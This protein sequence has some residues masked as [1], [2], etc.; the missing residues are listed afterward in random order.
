MNL[1]SFHAKC[2]DTSRTGSKNAIHESW[3]KCT[4]PIIVIGFWQTHTQHRSVARITFVA[5][6]TYCYRSRVWSITQ[7]NVQWDSLSVASMAF[8]VCLCGERKTTRTSHATVLW[9]VERYW[10]RRWVRQWAREL[11][12]CTEFT[13]L[14]RNIRQQWRIW[15]EHSFLALCV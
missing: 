13:T 2:S 12:F 7:P 3:L 1:Q 15:I 8:Y 9:Y 11:L 4:R 6:F 10:E 5:E 14:E